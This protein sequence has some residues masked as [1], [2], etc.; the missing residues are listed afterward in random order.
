MLNVYPFNTEYMKVDEKKISALRILNCIMK[1]DT[2][3]NYSTQKAAIYFR[4]FF[5]LSLAATSDLRF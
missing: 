5:A 1:I 3:N 4:F 2:L